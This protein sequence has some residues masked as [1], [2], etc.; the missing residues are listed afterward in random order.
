MW[1]KIKMLI[2]EIAMIVKLKIKTLSNQLIVVE[3]N[4]LAHED[5]NKNT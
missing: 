5:E 3:T 4:K 1:K 2:I